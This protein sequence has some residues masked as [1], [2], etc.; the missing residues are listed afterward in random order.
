M[1]L[2]LCSCSN[3]KTE[4]T[5]HIVK[6]SYIKGNITIEK[7]APCLTNN[8]DYIV[9]HDQIFNAMS[10]IGDTPLNIEE[11]YSDIEVEINCPSKV[12]IKPI[13]ISI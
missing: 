2:I 11:T 13:N 8:E 1:V 7:H 9:I 5:N 10:S 4:K 6:F 3:T 12:I